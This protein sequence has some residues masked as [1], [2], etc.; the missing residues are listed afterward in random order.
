M[1][2]QELRS[3]LK[4]LVIFA[5]SG[6]SKKETPPQKSSPLPKKRK[7]AP[8]TPTPSSPAQTPK[9]KKSKQ[10]QNKEITIDNFI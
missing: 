1:S 10:K 5:N 7:S 9:P 4:P 2:E 6:D 8:L 3:L